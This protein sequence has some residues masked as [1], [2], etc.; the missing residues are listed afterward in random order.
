MIA[1]VKP[2]PVIIHELRHARA[3]LAAAAAARVPVELWS[4]PGAAAYV[5]AG[6]YDAVVRR[7]AAETPQARF[8]AVLDCADRADLVQAALRQGLKEVC[9]RGAPGVARRLAGIARRYGATL[10]RKL[11]LA[12]DLLDVDD[13]LAACR[14]WLSG[15]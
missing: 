4:A 3:A 2:R 15:D 9:Y 14:T 8:V 6:W 11:P 5:G 10:H 7:A 1:A 12:L 13:P